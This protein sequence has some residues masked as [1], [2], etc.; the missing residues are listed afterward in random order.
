MP[1][2]KLNL[3]QL[4]KRVSGGLGDVKGKDHGMRLLDDEQPWVVV[5][6]KGADFHLDLLLRI[7]GRRMR[8][9]CLYDCLRLNTDN[10][11]R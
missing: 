9:L 2:R 4:A 11:Q 8:R 3:Q 1:L 7:C 5:S 6:L 10:L